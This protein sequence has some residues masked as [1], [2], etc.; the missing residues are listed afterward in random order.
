MSIADKVKMKKP[1]LSRRQSIVEVVVPPASGRAKPRAKAS[2]SG[3]A[4]EEKE[5]RGESAAK[6]AG[7]ERKSGAEDADDAELYP[8]GWFY[9]HQCEKK[10][11]NESTSFVRLICHL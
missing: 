2:T 10:R 9:C 3:K 7:Q 6:R 8:N 5:A 1:R 11:G 4:K